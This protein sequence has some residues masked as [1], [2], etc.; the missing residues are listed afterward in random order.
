MM[1]IILDL[2]N[3]SKVPGER[4]GLGWRRGTAGSSTLVSE[5][6]AGWDDHQ[7]FY[8]FLQV[9]RT[10]RWEMVTGIS[11]LFYNSAL[12]IAVLPAMLNMVS[13]ID[14]IQN[15]QVCISD[16]VFNHSGYPLQSL[17]AFLDAPVSLSL[18]FSVH[19]VHNVLSRGDFAWTPDDRRTNFRAV[20]LCATI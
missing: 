5:N 9:A 13:R 3:E 1:N 18:D 15:L 2:M 6:L 8:I 4:I 7:E 19:V 16:S 20:D 11:S 17:P 14:G 12:S 10:G